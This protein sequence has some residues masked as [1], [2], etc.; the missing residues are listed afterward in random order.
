MQR[1]R[2]WLVLLVVL[3]LAGGA[4]Y[5]FRPDVEKAVA[6][7]GKALEP[8]PTITPIRDIVA[9]PSRFA[10]KEVTVQGAVTSTS[11]V[12]TSGGWASRFY[13]LKGQGGEILVVVRQSLPPRGHSLTVTGIVAEGPKGKGLAPRLTETR[14]E[15]GPER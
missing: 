5:F 7:V 1:G 2:V 13:T 11:E 15:R 4:W 8:G 14:R 9:A 3:A 6:G 10:G 12:V